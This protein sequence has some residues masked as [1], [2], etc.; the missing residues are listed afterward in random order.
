MWAAVDGVSLS[1]AAGERVGIV[2]ESGSGKTT[3]GKAM[4]GIERTAAGVVRFRGQDI[5]R[6]KGDDL[7]SFRR[8]AQMIFQDP[9]GSLNPRLSVGSAIGE[10]LSVHRLASR[11]DRPAR[12]RELLQ[13]V[14]LDPD[15][16]GRYPHEFSGGQR[17][18][19][20]IARAL[21]LQPSLLVADEP[22]SALDVSV[23]A[24]ILN[25][26][27]DLSEARG[28]AVVLVAHDLAVVNYVCRRVLI[29]YRGRVVEE[30]PTEAVFGH[31]CHPYTKLLKSAVPDPD[32]EVAEEAVVPEPPMSAMAREGVGCAFAARCPQ[33]TARCLESAP[34]LSARDPGRRVAC[35][36]A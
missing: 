33:A 17:Q 12:V 8:G 27:R 34:V 11:E 28:M 20:G 13:Q 35:H 4:L 23:Q 1:I 24:Q 3:L 18:R 16:A 14:G 2:G 25:L 31:P 9:M 6:L 30:G 21:A 26:L 5:A 36:F 10:V 29:L 7:E 19:I 32:I 15:Y 22:V